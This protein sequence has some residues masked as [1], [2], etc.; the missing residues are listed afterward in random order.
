MSNE[1]K[2]NLDACKSFYKNYKDRIDNNDHYQLC[3]EAG[4][5][6]AK[7]RDNN[8]V[9]SMH[10]HSLYLTSSY[11]VTLSQDSL[12]IDNY[13]RECSDESCDEADGWLRR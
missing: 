3:S 8:I 6:S 7:K 12:T 5:S 1:E 2:Y 4:Y 11:D 10:Y 13:H 9:F